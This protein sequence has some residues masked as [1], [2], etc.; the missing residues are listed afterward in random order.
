MQLSRRF[1]DQKNTDPNARQ[2][3]RG[4]PF[5]ESDQIDA[6]FDAGA[7]LFGGRNQ[8]LGKINDQRDAFPLAIVLGHFEK[9]P[10]E[11]WRQGKETLRWPLL[12]KIRILNVV[13]DFQPL[14][15]TLLHLR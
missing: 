1:R 6:L 7:R 5:Q 11:Q 4:S 13:E 9:K 2:L 14:K 10:R 15:K 3:R 8:F 12:V